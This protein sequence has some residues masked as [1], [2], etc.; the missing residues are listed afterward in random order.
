MIISNNQLTVKQSG[1]TLINAYSLPSNF[2]IDS[3]ISRGSPNS[4][5][6]GNVYASITGMIP[7]N[8]VTAITSSSLEATT[9]SIHGVNLDGDLKMKLSPDQRNLIWE[10]TQPNDTGNW[11]SGEEG[12]STIVLGYN[13]SA[14]QNPFG[15][16]DINFVNASGNRPFPYMSYSNYAIPKIYYNNGANLVVHFD[17]KMLNFTTEDFMRTAVVVELM[18]GF[19]HPYYFELDIKDGPTVT[20]PYLNSAGGIW[21]QA[22]TNVAI[23]QWVHFD[24]PF[25]AFVNTYASQI[26]KNCFIEAFYLVNEC[27]GSGY[28]NYDVTN[29]ELTI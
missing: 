6:G 17:L 10:G 7:F 29:W 20:L 25:N 22:Y 1:I 26:G 8:S 16:C 19:G 15:I 13:L 4:W 12:K 3:A 24:I 2:Y 11:F 18:D 21:E 14:P 28:V 23:G 27:Y 5:I 9:G